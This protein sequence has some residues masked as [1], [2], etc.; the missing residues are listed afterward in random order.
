M[1]QG[2]GFSEDDPESL[3]WASWTMSQGHLERNGMVSWWPCMY[4]NGHGDKGLNHCYLSLGQMPCD[5]LWTRED[6][7][8]VRYYL[9]A[10]SHSFP[11][12]PGRLSWDKFSSPPDFWRALSPLY[13]T[14]WLQT[15]KPTSCSWE[16][17]LSRVSHN[18]HCCQSFG[19][20]CCSVILFSVW[21]KDTRS[22]YLWLFLPFTVYVK[23]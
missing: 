2:I 14:V 5:P 1:I 4:L 21:D 17:I 18:S 12:S 3:S 6:G 9:M 7:R 19:A 10:I 23:L 22:W 13:L 8:L 15:I 16:L 11:F 20:F